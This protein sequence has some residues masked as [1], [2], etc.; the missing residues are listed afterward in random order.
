MESVVT[1]SYRQRCLSSVATDSL[2]SCKFAASAFDSLLFST[3]L[4]TILLREDRQ[5]GHLI[6][7]NISRLFHVLNKHIAG[8]DIAARQRIDLLIKQSK[9]VVRLSL[10]TNFAS[11]ELSLAVEF[12]NME[13]RRNYPDINF[14]ELWLHWTKNLFS[15]RLSLKVN[16]NDAWACQ[17]FAYGTTKLDYRL[18]GRNLPAFYRC[19]SKDVLKINPF[20][21]N[22]WRSGIRSRSWPIF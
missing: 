2:N 7:C 1:C 8:L 21:G 11:K 14:D 19:L 13:C 10:I 22:V 5:N 9:T 17:I 12:E 20:Q 6:N 4:S 16:V 3:L 18:P 15:Y